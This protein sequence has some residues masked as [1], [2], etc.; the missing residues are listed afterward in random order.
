MATSDASVDET[1]TSDV[2]YNQSLESNV[3]IDESVE[4]YDA[5][6][7]EAVTGSFPRAP[8][9][10]L[11]RSP[12]KGR[13]T[14]GC[15]LALKI[16]SEDYVLSTDLCSEELD[17]DQA[18]TETNSC[19]DCC[20]ESNENNCSATCSNTDCSSSCA[21]ADI[22]KNCA[23]D[24]VLSSTNQSNICTSN[25]DLLLDRLGHSCDGNSNK[26]NCGNE[27]QIDVLCVGCE[28]DLGKTKMGNI[29]ESS[30]RKNGDDGGEN[31]TKNK[32]R[33][34]S[35]ADETSKVE[36]SKQ[37]VDYVEQ[38]IEKHKK[39]SESQTTLDNTACKGI[40]DTLN[41]NVSSKFDRENNFNDSVESRYKDEKNLSSSLESLTSSNSSKDSS[42]VTKDEKPQ[43]SFSAP[44]TPITP[45]A[46]VH[47]LQRPTSSC[48]GRRVSFPEDE[49]RLITSYLEPANPWKHMNQVTVDEI[50]NA[51]KTSC[52]RHKTRPLPT[53]MQ[54]I[55]ALPLV[56]GRVECLSLKGH[57]LDISQCEGL[58]EILRR[59]QF[60]SLDLESCSLDDDTAIPLFDMIE[61]YDTATHLNI[62][63]NFKISIRG[64]QACSRMLKRTPSVEYLDARS[65]NLNE[66]NMPILGRALRL[67]ARLHTL[68][69]ENCN[70]TG[71]P[72]IMLSAAL[73]L[74]ETLC[75]LY[76]SDNRIG[77]TDCIQLGNLL[78]ANTHLQ[79]LD[80]RNNN[81]QDNGC[82]HICEGLAEQPTGKGSGLNSLVLWNNHMT[83]NC[84][85]HVS[86]MLI[87]TKSLET[88]NVG[89]NNLTSE[90]VL[91]L[92]EGLMRNRVLIRLGL[93]GTR[94]SDEGAVA[95]AEYVA[96]NPTI[97]RIDL[98][99]NPIKVAG[100]MALSHSLKMN[101]TVVQMDLDTDPKGE[102]AP[103]LVEQHR[104]AQKEIKELCQ[105]NQVQMHLREQEKKAEA[106]VEEDH[107]DVCKDSKDKDN[108]NQ[109]NLNL[110]KISLTCD[111][112]TP[113]P[114]LVEKVE[115]AIKE[116]EEEERKKYSSPAPSPTPSPMPSPLKNRFKVFRVVEETT[117]D[118]HTTTTAP[119][120]T[121][122][123]SQPLQSLSKSAPT[124]TVPFTPVQP[125]S[126]Q[127][128]ATVQPQQSVYSRRPN[129]FSPGGRFTVTRV[130]E[131]CGMYSSSLPASPAKA[132]PKV[133]AE[134][135]KIVVSSPV[136]IER[137]FSLD[138]TCSQGKMLE[139][140]ENSESADTTVGKTSDNLPSASPAYLSGH[141]VRLKS[142]SSDSDDVFL[143][144]SKPEVKESS[145]PK[146]SSM[147]SNAFA[148]D[149]LGHPSRSDL[150]D[151]GFMDTSFTENKET[152][153][154]PKVSQKV[155]TTEGD[156]DSLLSSSIESGQGLSMESGQVV[157]SEKSDVSRVT[158]LP[159]P[160]EPIK[161]APLASMENGSFDSDSE[162]SDLLTQSSDSTHSDEVR[163]ATDQNK[164]LVAWGAKAEGNKADSP[165]V[166]REGYQE[167][168]NG[169]VCNEAK[170]ANS[171]DSQMELQTR[172]NCIK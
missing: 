99:E 66:Q 24:S 154:L 131:P 80:L 50:S 60:K 103:D 139:V 144:S 72:L 63:G 126:F 12:A 28:K 108:L 5:L 45:T 6:D 9:P 67:G 145:D 29:Q 48:R 133:D 150:T 169:N 83:H 20:V 59:V 136:K 53:V 146:D 112:P 68:H 100:L 22:H 82:A 157:S 92:K 88:L 17:G 56:G 102:P 25:T 16:D 85:V 116:E 58:E 111:T 118:S 153:A 101:T 49:T 160:V 73:K 40:S 90:G 51:Y 143:D 2:S 74:N 10:P 159:H 37:K 128:V 98:R 18:G 158:L 113:K 13:A 147:P 138:E 54:Q 167:V 110:R 46:E 26:E 125:N 34:V 35:G 62:S 1:L 7:D 61:Y 81:V 36:V 11:Q 155:A 57:R 27:A 124:T 96:D 164:P 119:T 161:R 39:S 8:T 75:E 91:R 95:L 69:L 30:S 117:Q 123:L 38:D 107:E 32:K 97:Q 142:D 44:P 65:T 165:V 170:D 149:T 76:L 172:H 86:K 132:I 79:L 140:K 127:T 171:N 21:D 162:D 55:M 115:Q 141:F 106:K 77:I 156:A 148:S 94:L 93:Q 163:I 166:V 151:S 104:A 41:E 129:R 70:L 31:I 23:V 152:L 84:T 114:I 19:K 33:D 64:W 87:I 14:S 137:G 122:S 52:D 121:N 71:R 4:A 105:T 134:K 109:L 43:Q 78:R 120:V 42:D 47:K 130:S 3:S 168:N 135:P 15:S 89:M